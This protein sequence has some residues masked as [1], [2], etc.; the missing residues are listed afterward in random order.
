MHGGVLWKL[1][2]AYPLLSGL[3]HVFV[4]FEEG[5][6]VHRLAAPDIAVDCPVEGQLQGAAV[7]AAGMFVRADESCQWHSVVAH[8]TWI[9][10][11]MVG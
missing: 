9:L 2:Y 7:E 11:A 3:A 6:D 10:D 8:R 4:C 1:V 5:A